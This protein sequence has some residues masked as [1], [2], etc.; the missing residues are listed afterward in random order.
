V[1]LL[2]VKEDPDC[3]AECDERHGVSNEVQSGRHFHSRLSF[4]FQRHID[5]R[6]IIC[7]VVPRAISVTQSAGILCEEKKQ[8]SEV[9]AAVQ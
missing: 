7:V 5:T 9:P 2:E 8:I 6:L 4:T 1:F 3:N